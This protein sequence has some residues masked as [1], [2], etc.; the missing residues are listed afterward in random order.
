MSKPSPDAEN[1]RR[2][3]PLAAELLARLHSGARVLDVGSGSGRNS[4]ALASAGLGVRS[5]PDAQAASFEAPDGNADAAIGTHAFLHGTPASIAEMAARVARALKAGGYFYATFAS[6][7][8][9]RFG[10]G[11]RVAEDAFAPESGE[12]AGVV[13]A[14]FNE[15]GVR[16]ALDPHFDVELITEEDVDA[17]VGRWAH[18]QRPAGSV[19]WFVRARKRH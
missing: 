5:I 17:I 1:L 16:R 6:K 8:D 7:R 18:A 12:E 11:T 19:H 10:T 14:Y 13:H 3:H 15:T 9:A 4:A 2:A